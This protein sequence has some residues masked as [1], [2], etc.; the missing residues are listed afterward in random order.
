MDEIVKYEN[1]R[2]IKSFRDFHQVVTETYE[3][4]KELC[5]PGV[6]PYL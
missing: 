4:W 6:L 1:T 3:S 2:E 5:E